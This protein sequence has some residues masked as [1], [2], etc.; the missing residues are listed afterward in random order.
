MCEHLNMMSNFNVP[1]VDW[2]VSLLEGGSIFSR[3]LQGE[4]IMHSI[5]GCALPNY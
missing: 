3:L 1:T 5:A 4:D 2:L